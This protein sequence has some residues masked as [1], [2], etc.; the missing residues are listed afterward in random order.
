MMPM[1]IDITTVSDT[2]AA[3]T[4]II[5]STKNRCEFSARTAPFA[6]SEA[7]SDGFWI[8][9]SNTTEGREFPFSV[10]DH[11]PALR[12]IH[13]GIGGGPDRAIIY[14]LSYLLAR[15]YK[16]LALVEN[17]VLLAPG[18]L[19]TAIGSMQLAAADGLRV[20]AATV[21][22]FDRRILFVRPGYAVMF[23]IGA[24]MIV[25]TREAAEAVLATYRSTSGKEISS[26]CRNLT[27][28][29]ISGICEPCMRE[30]YFYSADWFFDCAL[31]QMGFA[32]IGSLPAMAHNIDSDHAVT[33]GIRPVAEAQPAAGLDPGLFGFFQR[34]LWAAAKTI[35]AVG[36]CV[37]PNLDRFIVFPHQ[38]PPAGYSGD[39]R[40][41]WQQAC[42]PFE[43]LPTGA[44]DTL[45]FSLMNGDC[46][47]VFSTTEA[48]K[49]IRIV[50]RGSTNEFTHTGVGSFSVHIPGILR[51]SV[52]VEVQTD[53][54][55]HLSGII[56]PEPQPWFRG[57]ANWR[58]R[59]E[60][61][62]IIEPL[63]P[64]PA[65]P[66]VVDA[67]SVVGDFNDSLPQMIEG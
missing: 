13:R 21:R 40:T 48:N 3:T 63:T 5:Y 26:V 62:G 12:E 56:F 4:G 61:L 55:V 41:K 54:G 34:N 7:D 38:L 28:G 43:L 44:C 36:Y 31:M 50:A 52:P 30:D 37:E 24:G 19:S 27:R 16:Y 17:D 2:A 22:T 15:G 66:P 1:R 18:W 29:E 32:S 49:R 58:E 65:V 14:G 39:W 53:P 11:L 46:D 64:V 35:D 45:R 59:M 8:D 33:L 57:L 47:V 67:P 9:G 20:G 10:A 6:L 51:D 25:F 42:G 60:R 23:N